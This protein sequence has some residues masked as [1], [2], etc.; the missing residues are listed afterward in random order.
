MATSTPTTLA[1]GLAR[2]IEK[3]ISARHA[4]QVD[5]VTISPRPPG[6]M[7]RERRGVAGARAAETVPPPR[8]VEA[9]AL[10][11]EAKEAVD[12]LLRQET[13]RTAFRT[14]Y[15]QRV[16][17]FQQALGDLEA[18]VA[19]ELEAMPRPEVVVGVRG[20]QDTQIVISRTPAAGQQEQGGEAAE[21]SSPAAPAAAGPAA[22]PGMNKAVLRE[23]LVWAAGRALAEL[24]VN[25]EQPFGAGLAMQVMSHPQLRPLVLVALPEGV[26]QAKT[27][28]AAARAAPDAEGGA[29]SALP[30]RTLTRRSR[31]RKKLPLIRVTVKRPRA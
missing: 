27:A 18:D 13:N 15:R 16:A 11:G 6:V 28:E 20:R 3:Q 17:T 23:G 9:A 4:R 1:E 29:P 5:D 10:R 26:R 25:P 31:P 22:L 30:A 8:V 19:R 2:L 7:L 21:A 14:M 24:G 12:R